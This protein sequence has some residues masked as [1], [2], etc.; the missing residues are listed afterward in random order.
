MFPNQNCCQIAKYC[1]FSTTLPGFITARGW[2]MWQ[3]RH[4]LIRFLNTDCHLLYC[5]S[6]WAVFTAEESFQVK[7]EAKLLLVRVRHPVISLKELRE[8]PGRSQ[9]AKLKFNKCGFGRRYL[10]NASLASAATNSEPPTAMTT[11]LVSKSPRS[12]T[13]IWQVIRERDLLLQSLVK[14]CC[15]ITAWF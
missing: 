8:A 7:D 15:L 2:C 6:N 13:S 11:L 4:Q 3:P 14:S 12:L 1:T 5:I 10:K 9:R